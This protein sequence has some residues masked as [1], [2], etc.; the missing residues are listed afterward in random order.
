MVNLGKRGQEKS[1][2]LMIILVLIIASIF[3]Y[4]WLKVLL[5]N[6]FPT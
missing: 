3:L 6:L 1:K 4:I 5:P 2:L